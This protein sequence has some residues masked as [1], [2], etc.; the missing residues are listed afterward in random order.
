[1]FDGSASV[2]AETPPKVRPAIVV[3]PMPRPIGSEK[4]DLTPL[5]TSER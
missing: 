5:T 4:A 3:A 1:M 2:P